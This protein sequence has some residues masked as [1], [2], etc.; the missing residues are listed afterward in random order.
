MKLL[1]C[2]KCSDVFKLQKE[3]RS[4]VCGESKGKYL[5]DGIKATVLS[6]IPIGIDNGSFV[7]ALGS[8]PKTG[9]GERFE[10]FVIPEVCLSINKEKEL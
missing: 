3:M 8:R 4:C 1:F 10:A 6:G 9:M 7:R 2:P 5:K